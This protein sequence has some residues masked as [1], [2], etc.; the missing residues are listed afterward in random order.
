MYENFTNICSQECMGNSKIYTHNID[1]QINI[2]EDIW[3]DHKCI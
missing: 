2:A 1:T 3:M